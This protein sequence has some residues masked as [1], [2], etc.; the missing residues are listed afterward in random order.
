MKQ[1]SELDSSAKAKGIKLLAKTICRE[2]TS[3]GY[4]TGELVDLATEVLRHAAE[5]HA[6][7]EKSV[8]TSSSTQ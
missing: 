3:Q 4:A 2:L 1:S 7:A 6:P 5:H 8:N